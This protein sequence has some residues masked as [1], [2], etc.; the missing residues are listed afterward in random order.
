[1]DVSPIACWDPLL[2][3]V[4]AARFFWFCDQGHYSRV[5][6]QEKKPE[7]HQLIVDGARWCHQVAPTQTPPSLPCVFQDAEDINPCF[8]EADATETYGQ[9]KRRILK[10]KMMTQGFCSTHQ[11]M[12]AWPSAEGD[13]HF[14]CSG[15][16]CTDMSRAGKQQKRHG[17]TASVYV[18]HAKYCR[19]CKIPLV[20]IECT[21][22]ARHG[23]M[24]VSCRFWCSPEGW[25][26]GGGFSFH[27]HLASLS[28]F[29]HLMLSRC[30]R[31]TEELDVGMI[32]DL[33]GGDYN[34]Y[35]VLAEPED[36]GHAGVARKRTYLI[37]AHSGR[38]EI[39]HDP[40]E[41]W[42]A[43]S[44]D[45]REMVRTRPRDYFVAPRHEVE[46]E[47]ARLAARRGKAYRPRR[48]DL[49]YLLT[50]R[51]LDTMRALS[52][53]YQDCYGRKA[54]E[55]DD[56]VA[57][58]GDSYSYTKTWSAV[59]NKIPTFRT[60]VRSGIMWSFKH[61]RFMTSKEKLVCMGWPV[62][63]PVWEGMEVPPIPA[64]DIERASDLVGNGMHFTV[65]GVIQLLALCCF[66]PL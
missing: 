8:V 66:G 23:L 5:L 17:K 11:R 33:Y 60:S 27:V 9:K 54:S 59:S 28:Y 14:D 25:G 37:G 62:V 42:H 16:P 30:V 52:K 4:C 10:S 50:D 19:E 53:N 63:Q 61:R 2:H 1:M 38:T 56:L 36:V 15:L 58:L 26:G 6:P 49:S 29:I 40:F 18:T 64:Q 32:E 7:C 24:K 57:F 35:Q 3:C 12:C 13:V 39:L 47:A 20:V 21:T 46:R 55:D 48:Q 45:L 44:S 34:W 22:D 31:G 51:E 41:L 65:V 43:V